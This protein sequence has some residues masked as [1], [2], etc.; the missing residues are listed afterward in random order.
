M[1]WLLRGLLISIA[2]TACVAPVNLTFES[3]R[4][5]QKGQV[6]VQANASG[7]YFPGRYGGFTNMNFGVKAGYGVVDNYTVKV[8]YE[9]LYAPDI[10]QGMEIFGSDPD[11]VSFELDYY[12][13]ENKIRFRNGHALGLPF[14]TYSF[15][16]FV[17]D[18]RYYM[19]FPNDRNTFEWTIIPKA[20]LYFSPGQFSAVPGLSLGF[21][22]SKNLDRWAIRPEL[23]WDGYF[24]AGAALTIN[25]SKPD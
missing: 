9:H 11:A 5:L 20:H 15:N 13:L 14:A 10:A 3:S 7:Y 6:D 19:T 23:G 1:K 25:L 17:F 24:S 2:T 12:E 4:T 18:P 21:G 8:R 22:F 16:M